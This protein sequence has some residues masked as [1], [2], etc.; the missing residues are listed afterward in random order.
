[1]LSRLARRGSGATFDGLMSRK[2]SK[3]PSPNTRRVYE[4][5]AIAFDFDDTLAPDSMDSLLAHYGVEKDQYWSEHVHPR[6][7]DG[8]DPIPAA[9]YALIEFSRSQSDPSA[10]LTRR[11]L[12]EHGRKLKLFPGVESCLRRLRRQAKRRA[13]VDVEFYIISSG[14]GEVIRA[15]PAAKLF[16]NIWAS[17][18]HYD[19]TGEIAYIR[20]VIS[21][22]EKTRYLFNIAKGISGPHGFDQ[23]L[24]LDPGTVAE[25]IRIPL[26][27]I[28]YVGDGKTDIPCFSLI[29]QEK[30]FSLGV[31]KDT[32]Q[33]W[34]E[35]A[36]LDHGRR[37]SNL[38]AADFS[39]KSEM[40][41]SL[42]HAVES[43]CSMI[44]VH[45]LSAG[46]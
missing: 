46:E 36:N 37:L 9:F 10:R 8:W 4:R 45:R 20:K 1:M 24:D 17:D 18:F 34:G 13:G 27:H 31:F 21:H 40:T 19:R 6:V 15:T 11:R 28:V 26:R 38:V 41:R 12:V 39:S 2:S 33:K 44:A 14:I 5:I 29:N 16:K 25:G 22:T 43:L 3:S 42:T 30:G 23:P 35:Q 32:P 7:D